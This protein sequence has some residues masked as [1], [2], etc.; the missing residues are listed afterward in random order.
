MTPERWREVERI[1]QAVLDREASER[2]AF[3]DDACA[4]DAELRHEVESLLDGHRP[5]DRFWESGALKKAAR[6][7]RTKRRNRLEASD[8]AR[9]N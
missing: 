1:F 8:S 7:R 9:T 2:S 4:G 6:T 3:L 5:D